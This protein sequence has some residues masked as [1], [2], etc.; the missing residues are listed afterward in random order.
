MHSWLFFHLLCCSLQCCWSALGL[1]RL[2]IQIQHFIS[3]SGSRFLMTK[4]WKKINSWKKSFNILI[5]ICNVPYRYLSVGLDIGLRSYRRVLQ[6]LKDYT[7]HFKTWNFLPFFLCLW[8][9]IRIQSTKINTDP[10]PL[11]WF[12]GF[13]VLNIRKDALKI[14]SYMRYQFI[15][16]NPVE[17]QPVCV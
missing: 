14:H 10:D 15:I 2:W 8:G 9:H 17:D 11:H 13:L 5:K 1:I 16:V 6:L 7:Q 3:C 4:N 12:C